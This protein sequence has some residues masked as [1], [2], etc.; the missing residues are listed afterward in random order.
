MLSARVG[1]KTLVTRVVAWPDHEQLQARYIQMMHTQCPNVEEVSRWQAAGGRKIVI[2]GRYLPEGEATI[3]SIDSV[4][5]DVYI[6]PSLGLSVDTFKEWYFTQQR[7]KIA[8]CQAKLL[9]DTLLSQGHTL[10]LNDLHTREE[11]YVTRVS[12]VECTA[13]MAYNPFT[14]IEQSDGVSSAAN[15]AAY[16]T[17]W[18]DTENLQHDLLQLSLR[19]ASGTETQM[20]IDPT[21]RQILPTADCPSSFYPM[22]P[23][24]DMAWIDRHRTTVRLL[25]DDRFS[26]ADLGLW[27]ERAEP[28]SLYDNL[29][30]RGIDPSDSPLQ[31]LRSEAVLH[32]MMQ[33]MNKYAGEENVSRQLAELFAHASS[34][35]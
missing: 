22:S 16:P 32:G 9:L 19:R 20:Y 35:A 29:V 8:V 31:F 14:L 30:E 15:D 17:Y 25:R 34:H 33:V 27:L 1:A 3:L 11:C 12:R 24:L 26:I 13:Q 28:S 5:P 4:S 18:Q 7:C 2:F 21:F 23:G 6:D 10:A